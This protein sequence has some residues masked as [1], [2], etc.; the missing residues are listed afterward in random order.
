MGFWNNI[1]HLFSTDPQQKTSSGDWEGQ[2]FHFSN[3]ANS[4]FLELITIY[5]AIM[6]K[7]LELLVV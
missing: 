2:G 3:W 1:K 7:S 5:Y 4:N 6:K